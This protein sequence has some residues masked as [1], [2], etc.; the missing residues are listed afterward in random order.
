MDK[1]SKV[2][3]IAKKLENTNYVNKNLYFQKDRNGSSGERG[4]FNGSPDIPFASNL[5]S[6]VMLEKIHKDEYYLDPGIGIFNK[7]TNR[8]IDTIYW[9]E[10]PEKIF[11]YFPIFL[12][13]SS[14][15]EPL[16]SRAI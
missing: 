5:I 13:C 2:K 16:A 4:K 12:A 7:K 9:Y 14:S 8:L 3:N 10:N 1:Y 6:L 15:V 11:D